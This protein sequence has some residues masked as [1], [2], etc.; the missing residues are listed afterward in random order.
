MNRADPLASWTDLV[1]QLENLLAHITGWLQL[2]LEP[3]GLLQLL[4][5][6]VLAAIA[7]SGGRA[8]EPPI[9]QWVRQRDT[10]LRRMR[11]YAL[12][13]RRI[14]PILFVLLALLAVATLRQAIPQ[15]RSHLVLIAAN[16]VAVWIV[17]SITSRFIRNRLVARVVAVGAWLIAALNIL[18]LAQTATAVLD[19]AAVNIGD[20]RV[21]LLLVLKAA[22]VLTILFW[23]ASAISVASERRLELLEDMSPSMRV[24]AGKL[25]R[26]G[27]FTLAVFVGPESI[28]L[29]LTG[30]PAF[31]GAVGLGLG[32]GLRR[33][34]P[35]WCRASFFS[36]TGPSNRGMSSRWARRSAGSSSSMP[37]T[38]R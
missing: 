12:V 11:L 32:F 21:S 5:I 13:L 8:L 30:L 17:V 33:W 23:L 34:C 31:S 22:L 15:D 25:L 1:H 36:S 3:W 38:C 27:L 19:A 16:L 2:L 26:I 10:T 37:A 24:L 35:T 29:D 6:A 9:E 28:G 4:L 20:V 7:W 18:N 14:R